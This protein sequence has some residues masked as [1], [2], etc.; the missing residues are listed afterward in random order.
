MTHLKMVR[1]K[2][3]I[4]FNLVEKYKKINKIDPS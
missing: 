2:K 4:A 1:I 3:K